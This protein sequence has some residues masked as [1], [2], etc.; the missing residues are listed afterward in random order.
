[1]KSLHELREML[2]SEL[3]TIVDKGELSAGDLECVHKLTDTIKNI[4]KIEKLESEGEYSRSDGRYSGSDYSRGTDYSGSS[5]YGR[6]GGMHYVRGHYSRADGI[7]DQIR[8][9]M[10]SP[11]VSPGARRALNK[12]LEEMKR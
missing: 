6:R 4:D 11:S 5:Y 10:E 12:A 7:E 8:E 3:D 1:M 9:I 2:C